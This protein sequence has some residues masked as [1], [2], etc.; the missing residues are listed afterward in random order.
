MRAEPTEKRARI[1]PAEFDRT[2]R[3]VVCDIFPNIFSLHS[4]RRSFA[5]NADPSVDSGL[6]SLAGEGG[7]NGASRPAQQ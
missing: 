2:V 3:Y 5:P 4:I 6:S 1:E 7:T